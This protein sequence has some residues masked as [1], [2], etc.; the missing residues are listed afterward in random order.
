[1][2]FSDVFFLAT[3]TFRSPRRLDFEKDERRQLI[4]TILALSTTLA[5][6]HATVCPM[7]SLKLAFNK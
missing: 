4:N 1:M 5:K 7:V 2:F 3:D 6:L